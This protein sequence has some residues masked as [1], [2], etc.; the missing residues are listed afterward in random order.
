MSKRIYKPNSNNN[1]SST[2]VDKAPV[3]QYFCFQVLYFCQWLL[4]SSSTSRM[5]INFCIF[6][7][8]ESCTFQKSNFYQFLSALFFLLFVHM[9]VLLKRS[10][11]K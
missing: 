4:I 5:M 7:N 9:F 2:L 1:L 6:L 10:N 11:L 8:I 3:L